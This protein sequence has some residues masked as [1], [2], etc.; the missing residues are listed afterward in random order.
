MTPLRNF[1]QFKQGNQYKQKS[2]LQV[3][4]YYSKESGINFFFTF[5][6]QLDTF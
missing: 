5:S 4:R 6:C 3:I 2:F 1:P